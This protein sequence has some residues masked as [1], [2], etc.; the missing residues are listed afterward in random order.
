MQIV[1]RSMMGVRAA[2]QT[3]Q[4]PDKQVSVT[5]FPMIHIGQESFYRQ[6]HADALQ[7]DVV[8]VEGVRSPVTR[9]ITSSY[10][11]IDK[12]KLQLV[13]QPRIPTALD[14]NP[15]IVHADL[16]TEEFHLQ[17]SKLPFWL[18]L[19]V[20]IFAPLVGIHRRLFATRESLAKAM[21]MEDRLSSDEI[22][23]L[24]PRFAA[25]RQTIL[26]VRDQ[27]LI[28]R[29][30]EELDRVADRPNKIAII[31]GAAHMR[32]VLAELSRRNFRTAGATWQM[33]MAF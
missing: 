7:H 18:K 22:L 28:E 8:L 10:R 9:L 3:M 12:A 13:V 16:S 15:R 23:S 5:L 14:G 32:A 21:E 19:L 17:W 11:W 30:G 1:E 25:L 29:L 26:H 4:S 20:G 33:V 2:R 24:D 31:Y 27:R 6:V